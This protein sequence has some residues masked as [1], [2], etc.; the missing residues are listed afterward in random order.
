MRDVARVA[1]AVE[2]GRAPGAGHEPP[3]DPDAVLG[4]DLDV[5][6]GEPERRRRA[7][8]RPRGVVDQAALES[9]AAAR[10]DR[11]RGGEQRGHD[12][13]ACPQA[14]SGPGS[15]GARM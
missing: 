11:Q 5:L 6:V 7:L 15:R 14:A 9:G 8:D 1:V 13:G 12:A 4:R 3:V 2:H 10:E